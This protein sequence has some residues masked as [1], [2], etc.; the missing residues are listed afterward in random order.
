MR[1]AEGKAYEFFLNM[2]EEEKEISEA[3]GKDLLTGREAL[4]SLRLLPYGAAVLE[5]EIS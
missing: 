4:G 1:S 5:Q 2:S 3:F